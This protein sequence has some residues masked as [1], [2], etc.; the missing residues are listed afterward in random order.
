[1]VNQRNNELYQ[2]AIS[3]NHSLNS[4]AS[5]LKFNTPENVPG[6][7]QANYNFLNQAVSPLNKNSFK[8]NQVVSSYHGKDNPAIYSQNYNQ[9]IY[10][11]ADSDISNGIQQH[12]AYIDKNTDIQDKNTGYSDKNTGYIDKNNFQNIKRT[13]NLNN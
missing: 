4:Q 13:S 8:N 3:S 10:Q 11:R 7:T 9:K 12:T 2:S 5:T 6:V 1:M